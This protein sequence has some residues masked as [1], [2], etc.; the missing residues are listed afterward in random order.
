[1]IDIFTKFGWPVPLKNKN[2]Q[3]VKHS[4]ESNLITL[5][6][7]PKLLESADGKEFVS[8]FF[9]DFLNIINNRRYSQYTFLLSV[10]AERFNGTTRDLLKEL[11]FEK[12]RL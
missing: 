9:T 3:K 10:F 5:K 1:M 2:A 11:V 6:R 12:G 4:F 7:K 8:K